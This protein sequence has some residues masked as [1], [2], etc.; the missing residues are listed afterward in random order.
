[1][2]SLIWEFPCLQPFPLF[3][4]KAD[5]AGRPS[6]I[7]YFSNRPIKRVA[8]NLQT[9]YYSAL[10]HAPYPS[11]PACPTVGGL[12]RA[13]DVIVMKYGDCD[14][15][16]SSFSYFFDE[17]DSRHHG[18]DKLDWDS[19]QSCWNHHRL[20]PPIPSTGGRLLGS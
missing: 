13:L 2:L 12:Q 19:G 4:R 5:K 1:M 8:P 18:S 7:L 16:F 3:S 14:V 20:S 17:H 9:T 15:C 11:G 6:E 10:H